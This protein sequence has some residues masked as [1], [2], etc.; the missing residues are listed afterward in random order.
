MLDL[1]LDLVRKAGSGML[2]CGGVGF[3]DV[4]SL[5]Y[6]AFWRATVC[7]TPQQSRRSQLV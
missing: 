6:T 3:V 1:D 5:E 7:E 4:C 2:S